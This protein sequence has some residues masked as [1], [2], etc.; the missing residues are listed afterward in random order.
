MEHRLRV[1]HGIG[2]A[3]HSVQSLEAAVGSAEENGWVGRLWWMSCRGS[4]PADGGRPACLH[5]RIRGRIRM[6]P[7]AGNNARRRH[8]A[9]R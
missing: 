7:P 8:P 1:R 4:L 5:A 9:N 2:G 6:A 3:Q